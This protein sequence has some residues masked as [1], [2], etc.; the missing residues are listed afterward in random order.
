MDGGE[1][2]TGLTDREADGVRGEQV[3]MREEGGKSKIRRCQQGQGW[4]RE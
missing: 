4:V 3:L 2:L 1:G